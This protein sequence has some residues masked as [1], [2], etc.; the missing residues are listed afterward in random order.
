MTVDDTA[1]SLLRDL[2][3]ALADDD[4]RRA[5]L[6][7]GLRRLI[8]LHAG[9]GL[10][11]RVDGRDLTAEVADRLVRLRTAMVAFVADSMYAVDAAREDDLYDVLEL[12]STLQY[13]TDDLR[14][15]PAD[16]LVDPEALVEIDEDLLRKIDDLGPLDEDEEIPA[17]VPESH[18]WW[19]AALA[20][21]GPPAP[22]RA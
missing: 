7:Q 16:G 6:R 13:L 4:R 1:R 2:D 5:Y 3:A 22:T 12:R 14:G 19:R 20:P 15:T 17:G 8:G 11:A 9:G 21:G 18:W 10:P